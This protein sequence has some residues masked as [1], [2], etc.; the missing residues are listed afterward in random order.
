[1]Y[2]FMNKYIVSFCERKPFAS[3]INQETQSRYSL[4]YNE[5]CSTITKIFTLE[6]RFSYLSM[7]VYHNRKVWIDG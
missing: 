3:Q 7:Y 5:F 1:M 4:L 6:I 2:T